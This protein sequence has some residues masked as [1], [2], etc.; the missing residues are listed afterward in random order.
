GPARAAPRDGHPRRGLVVRGGPP[1]RTAYGAPGRPA[2]RA[3]CEPAG[4]TAAVDGRRRG[5]AAC[6]G[7]RTG[8]DRVPPRGDVAGR[9]VRVRA[10]P[11]QPRRTVLADAG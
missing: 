2:R 6:G 8:A 3:R 1:D 11:A 4:G 9:P 7:G 10:G 5:L